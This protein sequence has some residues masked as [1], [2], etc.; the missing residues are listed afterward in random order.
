[1]LAA[2]ENPLFAGQCNKCCSTAEGA[3]SCWEPPLPGDEPP[4][5]SFF[6]FFF[7]SFGRGLTVYSPH[8]LLQWSLVL[9]LKWN[10]TGLNHS[11]TDPISR[12]AL[13]VALQRPRLV[14]GTRFAFTNQVN[15]VFETKVTGELAI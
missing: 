2:V 9:S 14:W 10:P 7:G 8:H 11:T 4:D 1:M 6:F 15:S 13:E 3:V 12:H 5:N